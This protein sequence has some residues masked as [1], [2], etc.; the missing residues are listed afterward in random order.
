MCFHL[1][2]NVVVIIEV[3]LVTVN[4]LQKS[5]YFTIKFLK[6]V[7]THFCFITVS[8]NGRKFHGFMY[9]YV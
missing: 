1:Q 4:N 2:D 3:N 7:V 5:C 8:K 6:A 9:I